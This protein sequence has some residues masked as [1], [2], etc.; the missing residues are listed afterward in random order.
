M[1][2]DSYQNKKRKEKKNA[3][4]KINVTHDLKSF[5]GRV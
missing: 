5:H 3:D 2:L 4:T 1:F